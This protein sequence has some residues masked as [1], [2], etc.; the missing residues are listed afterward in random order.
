MMKKVNLIITVPDGDYCW[1]GEDN[2]EHFSN[3]GGH[4][5]CNLGFGEQKSDKTSYRVLKDEKCASLKSSAP[6]LNN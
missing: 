3:G 1:G 6:V 5:T 4:E 2:C